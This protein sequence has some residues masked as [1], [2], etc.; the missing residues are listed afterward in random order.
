MIYYSLWEEVLELLPRVSGI[1]SRSASLRACCMKFPETRGTPWL[2][3]QHPQS[4]SWSQLETVLI[5][6]L[7]EGE[8]TM[9]LCH[10]L[11]TGYSGIS[12]E[13]SSSHPG[14]PERWGQRV[15]AAQPLSLMQQTW[16]KGLGLSFP[17]RCPPQP[18]VMP[19]LAHLV[20]VEART[21]WSGGRACRSWKSLQTGAENSK[22]PSSPAGDGQ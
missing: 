22:A 18:P 3:L 13:H 16:S 7:L 5:P 17:V 9:Q 14:K 11:G 12:P 6:C 15:L 19:H 21:V 4:L 2:P 8:E 20:A 1:W 10:P